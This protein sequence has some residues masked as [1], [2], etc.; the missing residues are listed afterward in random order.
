VTTAATVSAIS[1]TATASNSIVSYA[2]TITLDTIPPGLR[3]G[4]TATV[5][6]TTKSSAADAL[7]VPAAAITTG[8][9]GT[10][11]VKVVKN[12]K[13]SSVIVVTGMVGDQGTEITS[14]LDAG[15]TIVLGTASAATAGTGTTRGNQPRGFFSGRFDTGNPFNGGGGSNTGGPSSGGPSSGGTTGGS[16]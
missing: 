15:E 10:S 2:T 16:R 13:T 14:G 6:I 7:Y 8:S 1:P 11:T 3:L 4:Q 5:T 12:G 9:D